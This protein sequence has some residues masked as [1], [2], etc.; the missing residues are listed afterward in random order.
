MKKKPESK[1]SPFE[2]TMDECRELRG[3]REVEEKRLLKRA[4]K[5]LP[6]LKELLAEVSGHWG[7]EDGIYR[8]Y[9]Q[10]FKVYYKLQPATSQIVEELQAL[11]PHL[12][13]NPYFRQIV[14]EGTGK[15]FKAAHNKN[16][17]KHTRPIVEAFFHARHMLEM[18]C[19][20]AEELKEPPKALPSGWATFLYLYNLR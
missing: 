9:H 17:L 14:A 7:Y 6:Q 19:K 2:L 16:W 1:P 4:K 13:L 8:F 5:R 3:R 15:E 12:K 10:S 11:A 20:Y 18:A